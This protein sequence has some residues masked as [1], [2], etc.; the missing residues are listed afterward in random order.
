MN[1]NNN[2]VKK[3][4][5]LSIVSTM[6]VDVAEPVVNTGV[7]LTGWRKRSSTL[8]SP[9][10][11]ASS[12]TNPNH[13]L[14]NDYSKI[15]SDHHIKTNMIDLHSTAGKSKNGSPRSKRD[16]PVMDGQDH[17]IEH[18]HSHVNVFIIVIT[19]YGSNLTY[20]TGISLSL[21]ISQEIKTILATSI[22]NH[23]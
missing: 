20:R 3:K 17:G 7:P 16:H 4:A 8:S 22:E 11:S 6:N 18:K 15:P 21:W 10:S 12:T 2:K 5:D 1:N 9:T 19:M 13:L 14:I 23:P